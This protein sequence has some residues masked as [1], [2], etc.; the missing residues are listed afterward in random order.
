M[1]SQV[2]TQVQTKEKALRAAESLLGYPDTKVKATAQV[3]ADYLKGLPVGLEGF[4]QAIAPEGS[5]MAKLE[6][7]LT[8]LCAGGRLYEFRRPVKITVV[9]SAHYFVAWSKSFLVH[10]TGDTTEEALR[11]FMEEWQRHYE[12]LLAEEERLGPPLQKELARI[13]HLLAKERDAA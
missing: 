7:R 10:G 2:Q 8:G 12:R 1:T 9:R 13:R 3:V 11:D 4:L 6:L 5:A